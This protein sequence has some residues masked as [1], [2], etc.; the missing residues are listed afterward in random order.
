MTKW[1]K[2]DRS[3]GNVLKR[4][5]E[6][7]LERV[8]NKPVVWIELEKKDAPEY[9]AATHKLNATVVQPDLSDLSQTVPTDAKRV[10]GYEAVALSDS[11][12]AAN[13]DAQYAQPINVVFKLAHD[14]ENRIRALESK[15]A[16]DVAGFQKHLRDN[17]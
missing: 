1:V 14:Q 10:E 3:T 6:D 13:K 8:F 12:I 17:F 9:D 4:R 5:T 7:N 15:D 16:L 2:I 11:E